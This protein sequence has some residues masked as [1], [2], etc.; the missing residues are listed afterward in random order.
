[1]KERAGNPA[2]RE[3]SIVILAGG[4]SSRM[5]RSAK[6]AVGIEDSLAKEAAQKPKSMISVGTERRPFLDYLL[7]NV[8]A[9]GYREVVLL[10]GQDDRAIREYYDGVK[11][12][13]VLSSLNITFVVQPIPAG[14]SKPLGTADALQRSLEARPD[15]KSKQLTVCNSDNLYSIETLKLLLA[16]TDRNALIDYDFKGLRFPKERI[17]QFAVL[18]KDSEGYL[19]DILE[20][21][22]E[23]QLQELGESWGVSMNIFRFTYDDILQYLDAVPLHPVRNEKELPG[24]VRMMVRTSPKA[25]KAYRRAEYVPDLTAAE[26]IPQVQQF[27]R[28]QFPNIKF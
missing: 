24:A 13:P 1:M 22:T 23:D 10:I 21:P 2:M 17:L 16:S 8:Q 15:W 14:R 28:E 11:K 6:S 19:K 20:K 27:I 26:D 9:G 12:P 5:K 18:K 7:Y 4:I 3:P 25:V